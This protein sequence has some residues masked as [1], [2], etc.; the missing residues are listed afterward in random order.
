MSSM[1]PVAARL[2]QI[3]SPRTCIMIA[4]VMFA[5]GGIVTSQAL[6]LKTFLIGRAICGIGGAGILT[7]SFILVLELTS[8]KRR[9]VFIG[10]VNSGFTLGVSLGA[11]VAGALLSVTGWRFLFLI[12]GP[13]G[14]LAGMGIYFSIPKSF[15]SSQKM[16]EGSITSKL[17]KIDYLGAIALIS[18]I[19]LFLFGLSS[20]EIA[21]LPILI[22]ILL[23]IVFLYIELRIAKDPIIPIAVLKSRGALLS[24]FAQLGIMSA[25]WSV[26]FY[27]PVYAIAVRSWSPASAGSILVPTNFGFALGGIITG[28]LH[29]KRAGSF[30]LPSIMSIFLFSISIF[31]F[32]QIST[33]TIAAPLYVLNAFFNGL[34]IGAALNYTLAHLLHL[35]PPSTHFISTSLLSTF[36]G[37]AGSFG[38]AIGGGAFVRVIRSSLEKGFTENGGMTTERR[39]LVRKLVG[40]PALVGTLDGIEKQIA[41]DA[42]VSGLK[43]LWIGATVVALVMIGVQAGTGWEKGELKEEQTGSRVREVGN[44]IGAENEEWEEGMA[45]GV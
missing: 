14:I 35:T 36:R 10:L 23:L 41:V 30:W 43:A 24:C 18:T 7:I 4:A 33:P 21:W 1:A 38:S 28:W 8:R 19:V 42:Y 20:P 2:A 37:F 29:V 32:S 44:E 12:Q 13:L 5:I 39:E 25:R 11:V 17:A 15:T 31:I 9:G 45:Q 3:F 26:L 22:S 34:C 27:T 6:D 40:S 16:A